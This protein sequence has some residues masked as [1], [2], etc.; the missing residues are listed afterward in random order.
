MSGPLAGLFGSLRGEMNGRSEFNVF[1][2]D[3]QRRQPARQQLEHV[4]SDLSRSAPHAMPST[5]A[6]PDWL[7][8]ISQPIF[9]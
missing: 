5:F 4:A 6:P 2:D 1:I 7:S 3:I 9:D 8:Q